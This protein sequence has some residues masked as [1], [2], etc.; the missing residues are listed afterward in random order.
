MMKVGSS[1]AFVVTDGLLSLGASSDF[2]SRSEPAANTNEQFSPYSQCFIIKRA[3]KS[4]CVQFKR[5]ADPFCPRPSA[6][7][8]FHTAAAAL[9]LKPTEL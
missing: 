6:A 1:S 2:Y 8:S 9:K 3:I 4:F 7:G 5:D